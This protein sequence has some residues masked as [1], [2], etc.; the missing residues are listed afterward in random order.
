M[1]DMIVKVLSLPQNDNK[2]IKLQKA[3][4]SFFEQICNKIENTKKL[5]NMQKNKIT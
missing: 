1:I 4:F 3:R 5:N 2:M